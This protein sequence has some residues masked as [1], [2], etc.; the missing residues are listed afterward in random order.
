MNYHKADRKKVLANK[1]TSIIAEMNS[2]LENVFRESTC[3]QR[4]MTAPQPAH[5]LYAD[6]IEHSK[7]IIL[8]MAKSIEIAAQKA[9]APKFSKSLEL[10]IKDNL[11]N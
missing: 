5:R 8:Q 7:A 10:T 1:L 11:V 3:G 4:D 2:T 6:N 9:G